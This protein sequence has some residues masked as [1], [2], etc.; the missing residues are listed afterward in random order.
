MKRRLICIMVCTSVL[1]SFGASAATEAP[2]AENKVSRGV[3]ELFPDT[4]FSDGFRLLNMDASQENDE[5]AVYYQYDG[6]TS[7]P[8]WKMAQWSS[9]H[10]LR[11]PSVT[12]SSHPED[13]V[14]VLENQS[15]RIAVNPESGELA[16]KLSASQ[17]YDAPRKNNEPWPHLLIEGATGNSDNEQAVQLSNMTAL[18]LTLS[19]K[20]TEFKDCMPGYKDR[21]RH[22]AQFLMY[23]YIKGINASGNTEMM[24]FGLPLFD[25]R[26]EYPGEY[27]S[28]DSGKDD[29][30]GLF[31]YNI[32][33]KG[34]MHD[35][36]FEQAV[37]VG[38]DQNEWINI[39]IDLIP[40]IERAKT[41]AQQN[42]FLQGM[43]L[44]TMYVDGVNLGWEMPGTY[45]AEMVVKN[46]SLKS[47]VGWK[48]GD[49]DMDD[50]VGSSDALLALQNSVGKIQLD[51]DCTFIADVDRDGFVTT[52]DAL[53]I[54]QKAVG[55]IESL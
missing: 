15:K 35:S 2:S 1:G 36:F 20:L 55:K 51:D 19:Q 27:A 52:S 16:L 26:Y 32:P 37:P 21:G 48:R 14:F 46:L 12:T 13:S 50:T 22:A 31:V 49:I 40:Y 17:I 5:T 34:F 4:D 11:D 53:R 30:S 38:S 7:L 33:A 45:D 8:S 54:L 6:G 39:D 3:Y 24:W 41:L 18:R 28:P 47:Y 25:N 42:G 10:D 44:D 23:L 43:E 29:A 9:K